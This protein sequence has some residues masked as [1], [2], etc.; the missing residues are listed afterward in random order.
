MIKVKWVLLGVLVLPVLSGLV[1][2]TA[3]RAMREHLDPPE[4]LVRPVS[5]GRQAQRERLEKSEQQVIQVQ[6]DRWGQ[7]VSRDNPVH[8]VRPARQ[9]WLETPVRPENQEHRDQ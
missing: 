7:P 5:E 6:P 1:A 9:V 8:P 2:V 3:G 4:H